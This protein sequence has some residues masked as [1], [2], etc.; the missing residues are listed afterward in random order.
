MTVIVLILFL[1]LLLW[2][3]FHYCCCHCYHEYCHYDCE[4][5]CSSEAQQQSKSSSRGIQACL[6]RE[7]AGQ[8][9]QR[10]GRSRGDSGRPGLPSHATSKASQACQSAARRAGL[11]A[12]PYLDWYTPPPPPSPPPF[13]STSPKRRPAVFV[14]ADSTSV[15]HGVSFWQSHSTLRLWDMLLAYS[16]MLI[17]LLAEQHCPVKRSICSAHIFVSFY[18]HPYMHVHL[19]H[20]Y[21]GTHVLVGIKAWL[22]VWP[23]GP[24]LQARYR[25]MSHCPAA[26]NMH[27]RTSTYIHIHP[28]TSTYMH[29]HPHTS[30][31]MHIHAHTCLCYMCMQVCQESLPALVTLPLCRPLRAALF[32]KGTPN[33]E[34]GDLYDQIAH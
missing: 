5:C 10:G 7:R 26:C 3:C 16:E 19:D 9:E 25:C 30:T 2:Q 28:H 32:S 22:G 33:P 15:P 17:G 6:G 1:P 24:C 11:A 20:C 29:I 27:A 34:L 23:C 8:D 18:L 13:C 12:A 4:C 31:Y 14:L 21:G